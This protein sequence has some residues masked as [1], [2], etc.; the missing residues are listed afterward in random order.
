MAAA[1]ASIPT[2]ALRSTEVDKRQRGGGGCSRCVR[3]GKVGGG[4]GG[5]GSGSDGVGPFY[6][7]AVGG[8]NGGGEFRHSFRRRQP[9]S[10]GSEPACVGGASPVCGVGA[11]SP[12]TREVGVT[13]KWARGHSNGWRQRIR[14]E[15]KI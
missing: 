5:E 7:S 1:A 10:S 13:D 11:L 12:K 6:S 8:G 14:F 9:A 2:A 15:I 4:V 3:K